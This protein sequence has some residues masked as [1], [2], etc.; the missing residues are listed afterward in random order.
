MEKGKY[1]ILKRDM[2]QNRKFTLVSFADVC[3]W[4]KIAHM[5][6]ISLTV[7]T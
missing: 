5:H 6:T 2:F 7:K 4:L 1:D 3:L